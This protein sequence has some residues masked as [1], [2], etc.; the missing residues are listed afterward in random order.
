[1]IEGG[2]LSYDKLHA[3]LRTPHHAGDSA[4]AACST[5]ISS[6]GREVSLHL[7]K[8]NKENMH[9]YAQNT[10]KRSLLACTRSTKPCKPQCSE[11]LQW[12]SHLHVHAASVRLTTSNAVI[13]DLFSILSLLDKLALGTVRYECLI[14]CLHVGRAQTVLLNSAVTVVQQRESVTISRLQASTNTNY[15]HQHDVALNHALQY[16]PLVAVAVHMR[17]PHWRPCLRLPQYPPEQVNTQHSQSYT[18]GMQYS[19]SSDVNCMSHRPVYSAGCHKDAKLSCSMDN[20]AH[21]M[22]LSEN[23]LASVTR[24]SKLIVLLPHPYSHFQQET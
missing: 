22:L 10:P 7:P 2:Y 17:P 20:A 21:D 15:E 23:G 1:M 5:A 19:V 4:E 24:S 14:C 9:I 13:T 18:Q 3:A 11:V 12:M 16:L 8:A 6:I